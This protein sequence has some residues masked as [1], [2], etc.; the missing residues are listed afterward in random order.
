MVSIS[1]ESS[2]GRM[3]LEGACREQDTAMICEALQTFSHL[4]V[5]L[6]VDLSAATRLDAEVAAALVDE[7]RR[8]EREGCRLSLVRRRGSDADQALCA[9]EMPGRRLVDC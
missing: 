6:K 1:F 8:V 7:K 3:R 5:T 4:A 9:A 2:T